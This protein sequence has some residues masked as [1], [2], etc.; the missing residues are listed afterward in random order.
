MKKEIQMKKK[1]EKQYLEEIK[2]LIEE[3]ISDNNSKS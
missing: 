2:E 1:A 3:N